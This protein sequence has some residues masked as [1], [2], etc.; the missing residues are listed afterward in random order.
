MKWKMWTPKH[1]KA[2]VRTGIIKIYPATE[3]HNCL[4]GVE[5]VVTMHG[6]GDESF[7]G[8]YRYVTEEQ[9][10]YAHLIAAAPELYEALN[11]LADLMQ[12]V[13]EGDYKP[14]RFTLQVA[15]AA[16]AKARGGE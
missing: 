15:K 11:E 5:A 4:S 12:G 8:G 14:D 1:L 10:M 7:P 9:T 3:N 2:D 16:L 6:M 13:I